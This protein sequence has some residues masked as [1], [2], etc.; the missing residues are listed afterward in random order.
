[1]KEDL[2]VDVNW[3]NPSSYRNT[4]LHLCAAEENLWLLALLLAHPKIDVNK[5][6]AGGW[7][8]LLW[9]CKDG[10]LESVVVLL[11]DPRVDVNM[12]NLE[13]VT[14]LWLTAFRG[15]SE[16]ARWLV[17]CRSAELDLSLSTNDLHLA[18]PNTSALDIARRDDGKQFWDNDSTWWMRTK[19][20]RDVQAL[21][22]RF[23]LDKELTTFEARLELALKGKLKQQQ[24][25]TTIRSNTCQLFCTLQMPR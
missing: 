8:P 3:G 13:G 4:A 23:V 16:I 9:A 11:K 25:A 22:T 10:R 20:R 7:T 21:L 6:N 19:G 24:T 5:K 17:V 2:T 14:A 18:Y 15:W 12:V 1:M